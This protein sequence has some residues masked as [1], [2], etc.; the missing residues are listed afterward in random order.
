MEDPNLD[1]FVDDLPQKDHQEFIDH[2]DLTLANS[3]FIFDSSNSNGNNY[4]PPQDDIHFQHALQ[5]MNSIKSEQ[6]MRLSHTLEENFLSIEEDNLQFGGQFK[7]YQPA[8][9][10]QQV[11]SVPL[12]FPPNSEVRIRNSSEINSQYYRGFPQDY[13]IDHQNLTDE[14]VGKILPHKKRITKK[15]TADFSFFNDSHEV[16][17]DIVLE[18]GLVGAPAPN[19]HCQLCGHPFDSQYTFFTHLKTHY[20]TSPREVLVES[21]DKLPETTVLEKAMSPEDNIEFSD[22][23][24]MLEGIRNVVDK[25]QESGDEVEALTKEVSVSWFPDTEPQSQPTPLTQIEPPPVSQEDPNLEGILELYKPPSPQPTIRV[26]KFQVK[27]FE[28]DSDSIEE[29]PRLPRKKTHVCDVCQKEFN[30]LNALKYHYLSHT[31][32][33]A[34]TCSVC[35]KSFFAQSALKSHMRLHTGEK[36]YE[37]DQCKMKFRQWGDLKYHTVSKHSDIKNYQCEFCGKAFSRKYSLVIH[38]RIHTNERNYKCDICGKSFRAS[39]YLTSHRK[40]HTGERPHECPVCGKCFRV[41]GDL[42]RHKKIHDKPNKKSKSEKSKKADPDNSAKN[43]SNE[44]SE[45]VKKV[46]RKIP[47]AEVITLEGNQFEIN[48]SLNDVFPDGQG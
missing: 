25:V 4:F 13:T 9:P 21:V 31:G 48:N 32:E 6:N 45:D 39:M 33:R 5:S 42:T 16:P 14:S 27:V 24:D 28:S 22:P 26:R 46:Y 11:Y 15:L 8:Q 37:C 18:N 2:S 34:H 43:F 12:K 44:D 35:R 17:E 41:G 19:F 7:I 1:M 10:E 47:K 23:E 30:S 29:L 20:E 3:D 38:R 40:I 36:P